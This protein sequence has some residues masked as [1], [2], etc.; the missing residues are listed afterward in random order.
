MTAIEKFASPTPTLDS[1]TSIFDTIEYL[2]INNCDHAFVQHEG[3]MA[4]IVSASQLLENYKSKDM[5]GATVREYMKPLLTIN[6][7]EPKSKAAEIMLEHGAEF[8]AV[9]NFNGVLLGVAT[10]NNLGSSS[11]V[12]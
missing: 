2:I 1:N 9:T 6:G 5:S 4:G 11:S 3:E 10:F 8:I 12:S 7:N